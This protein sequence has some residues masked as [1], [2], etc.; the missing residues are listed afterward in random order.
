MPATPPSKGANGDGPNGWAEYRRLVLAE[1]ERVSQ[2]AAK[3][4]SQ[5]TAIQLALTQAISDART[6]LLDKIRETASKIDEDHEKKLEAVEK[7]IERQ[8]KDIETR[9]QV[10]IK[11]IKDE[12]DKQGKDVSALKAKAALLGAIAGFVVALVGVIA[13]I[14]I[15]KP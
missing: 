14:F 9:H 5:G 6:H 11:S 2:A 12:M 15:K 13:S 3:A 4:E 8:L 1:I 10:E 7:D